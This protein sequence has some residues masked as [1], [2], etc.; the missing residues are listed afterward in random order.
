MLVELEIFRSTWGFFSHIREGHG[1]RVLTALEAVP[2]AVWNIHRHKRLAKVSM[3][4]VPAKSIMVKHSL[5][6]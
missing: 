3:D 5:Y 2:P 1:V 4:S 6:M